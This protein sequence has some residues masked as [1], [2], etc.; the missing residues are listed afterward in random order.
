M[1]RFS[2][3]NFASLVCAQQTPP[4]SST[5]SAFN[6]SPTTWLPYNLL[7]ELIVIAED[8]ET[9]PSPGSPSATKTR[10][11]VNVLKTEI[12][13][14]IERLKKEVKGLKTSWEEDRRREERR[15]EREMERMEQD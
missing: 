4:T 6:K 11:M 15:A 12:G 5:T 9:R 13:H 14:R 7:D 8:P 3:F 1:F 2:D 10:E